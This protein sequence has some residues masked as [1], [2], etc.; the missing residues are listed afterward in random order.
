MSLVIIRTVLIVCLGLSILNG[1]T[2]PLHC[3]DQNV[4]AVV[5]PFMDR[6]HSDEFESSLQLTQQRFAIFIY[7]NAAIVY[8]EADFVN[9]G[10]DSMTMELALPSTGYQEK[11]GTEIPYISNGIL[12]VQMWIAGERAEPEVL[13]ESDIEWY[14][15][16]AMFPPSVV[17]KVK[18]LFWVQTSLT[19]VDSIP[20]LD[21]VK[22]RDGKRGFLLNLSKAAIWNDNIGSLDVA[23]VFKEGL[24]P[25]DTLDA[26]P[27]N[28]EVGDSTISWTMRDIEPSTDDNIDLYYNSAVKRK[29]RMDTMKKLS[30]FNISRGYDDVLNYVRQLDEE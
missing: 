4:I 26:N 10:Q 19:D 5:P 21:T 6:Q 2:Y 11:N 29:S 15:I 12:S 8:S 30:R 14:A 18:A 7:R 23:V 28:Y 3:Q 25:N 9:N 1:F 16:N 22:I 20:G 17:T 24:T 27:D 13:E